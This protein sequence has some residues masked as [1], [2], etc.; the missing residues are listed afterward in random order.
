MKELENYCEL[1]WW[2]C[3]KKTLQFKGQLKDLLK[4]LNI[5]FT[6]RKDVSE[7]LYW[8]KFKSAYDITFKTRCTLNDF[9][10]YAKKFIQME[11]VR[12]GDK[13]QLY[14][15]GTYRPVVNVNF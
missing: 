10:I 5:T 6:K 8:F 2:N 7:G 13:S 12:M 14:V 4:E 15:Q 9:P 3:G 1:H 11:M